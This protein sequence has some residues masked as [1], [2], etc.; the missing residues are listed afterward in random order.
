MLG[1]GTVVTRALIAYKWVTIPNSCEPCTDSC[2]SLICWIA[3][4]LAYSNWPYASGCILHFCGHQ[5]GLLRDFHE[6]TNQAGEFGQSLRSSFQSA[7]GLY[8]RLPCLHLPF[9]S[10]ASH[11]AGNCRLRSTSGSPPQ[12]LRFWNHP[13]GAMSEQSGCKSSCRNPFIILCFHPLLENCLCTPASMAGPSRPCELDAAALPSDCHKRD[14]CPGLLLRAAY[15]FT[16]V[17]EITSFKAMCLCL[18]QWRGHTGVLLPTATDREVQPLRCLISNAWASQ[19]N[20]WR[21]PS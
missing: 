20:G 10:G 2:V 19:L 7:P 18:C 4:P 14:I 15:L 21:N 5:F 13:P 3:Q 17:K 12:C 1:P 11:D 6:L 9:P 8:L 16:F